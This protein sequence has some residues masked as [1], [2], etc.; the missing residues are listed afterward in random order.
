MKVK[1]KDELIELCC[2]HSNVDI[3]QVIALIE[4]KNKEKK[5]YV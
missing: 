5:S 4:F 1:T 2:Y 3:D